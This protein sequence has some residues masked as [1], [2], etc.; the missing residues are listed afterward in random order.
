MAE[1]GKL[2]HRLGRSLTR[3]PSQRHLLHGLLEVAW[4]LPLLVVF[5][6]A[7]DL[8]E[9]RPTFDWT[10]LRLAIVAL[11][12]PA[13]GEELLFRAAL[14]PE[15]EAEARLPLWPLLVSVV[16]FVAWHPLQALVFGPHWAQT[17]LNPWFLAAV[18]AFGVASA[19]LYWK[20]ASLWPSV[21]LHWM[22][23]VG[24]KALLSGPSP[25]LPEGA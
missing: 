25:W 18:A 9:W 17:V 10:I 2:L 7:G 4:L 5:G 12:A 1:S 22:I 6:T 3:A 11:M 14:L 23:V 8:I 21:A 24:W 20:T 13:I 16:L 19:R 15:P